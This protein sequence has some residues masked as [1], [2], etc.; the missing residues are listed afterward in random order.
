MKRTL[1]LLTALAALL[2]LAG[3][4]IGSAYDVLSEPRQE[5]AA[6][7]VAADPFAAPTAEPT[8]EPTPEPTAKP[9]PEPTPEPT[10]E[11]TPEPTPEPTAEPTPEPTAEPAPTPE[12]FGAIDGDVY[13][14]DYFGVT[15]TLAEGWRFLDQTEL[16]GRLDDVTGSARVDEDVA[17]RMEDFLASGDNACAMAAYGDDQLQS[18]NVVVTYLA[19]L[20]QYLSE[21]ELV[22]IA[23]HQLG[24]DETGD[25]ASLGLDGAVPETG[26]WRFAGEKHAGLRVEYTDTSLGVDVP[27]YLQ[28]V[29]ILRDDYAM[30]VTMSSAFDDAPLTAI[31]AMFAADE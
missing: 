15:C 3:C 31:A 9:T 13:T 10:A 14:N 11:P 20:G 26:S 8:A 17:G 27:I 19:G 6:P 28:I 1:A 4:G 18:V 21:E 16:D 2:S 5:A 30:Q 23:L 29:Y 12:A 7:D 22:Q 25:L 24:V